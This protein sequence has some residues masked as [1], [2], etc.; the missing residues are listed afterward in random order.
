MVTVCCHGRCPHLP[1][2]QHHA[3]GQVGVPG[4]GGHR[5]LGQAGHELHALLRRHLR[6]QQDLQLRGLAG[7]ARPRQRGRGLRVPH[8]RELPVADV[9]LRQQQPGVERQ[10]RPG[11]RGL[12]GRRGGGGARGRV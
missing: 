9:S 4:P 8:V 1:R 11:G 2:A 7:H 12:P 5:G 6:R 10:L 3:R